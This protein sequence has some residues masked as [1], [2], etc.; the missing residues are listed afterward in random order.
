MFPTR[1]TFFALHCDILTHE[2]K[3]RFAR[4]V[5]GTDLR[6]E[7]TVS[8]TEWGMFAPADEGRSAVL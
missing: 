3:M 8:H 5:M 6:A 2:F 1:T 7:R 4:P